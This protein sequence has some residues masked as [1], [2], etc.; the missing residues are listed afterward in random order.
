MIISVPATSANLGPGFDCLGL[1]LDF[2]NQFSITPSNFS[3]IQ[4]IGEGEGLAKFLVDNMFVKIFKK[5]LLDFG[6]QGNE[7]RF[8]FKNKIPVSRGMGSS[9]AVI[10]GAISSAYHFAKKEIDKQSILNDALIYESHPDN[11]TPAVYGG[12]NVCV[13]DRKKVYHLKQE[14]PQIFKAVMVVPNRSISTKYSR[15]TLPKRYSVSD[16]VFNI[17]R[18]SMMSMAFAQGKWDVLTLASRDKFHQDRRMKQ[19]PV[20]FAVQ[21]IALANGALMSTLS[22]SGS[23]FFNMCYADDAQKL[24]NI[25]EKKFSNFR[26]FVLGF[27]NQG[28]MIEEE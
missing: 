21:K 11:I 19:F 2:R 16:S 13:V 6:I 28:V 24:A 20:L 8:L 18:S 10:V 3:S 22:G 26:V 7:F 27:D 1:S 4:I 23:S 9:S 15:Q 14:I 5:T 12:F 17:S 25:F